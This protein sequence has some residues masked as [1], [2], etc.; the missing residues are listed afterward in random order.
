[1]WNSPISASCY[2]L[3]C[4]EAIAVVTWSCRRYCLVQRRSL[5]KFEPFFIHYS[6]A[7][8]STS[9]LADRLRLFPPFPARDAW[10]NLHKLISGKNLS[11][12]REV[13]DNWSALSLSACLSKLVHLR[14]LESTFLVVGALS[15]MLT[16]WR[17]WGLDKDVAR[18]HSSII[19]QR[20]LACPRRITQLVEANSVVK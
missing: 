12:R 20:F 6:T 2:L 10:L 9:N 17:D 18:N 16:D 13:G 1:M 3:R 4:W 7:D 15:L 19:R 11:S 14:L 8:F 5:I